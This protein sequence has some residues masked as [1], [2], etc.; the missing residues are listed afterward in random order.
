MSFIGPRPDLPEHI[1]CYEGE[2]ARKLMFFQELVDIIKRIIEMLLDGSKD[3][4]M[5]FTM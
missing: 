4:E 1:S 2:E 3:Y 5:M